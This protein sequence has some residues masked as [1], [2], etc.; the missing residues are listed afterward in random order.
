MVNHYQYLGFLKSQRW[1]TQRYHPCE[2]LL[3]E[4]TFFFVFRMV[5]WNSKYQTST[6]NDRTFWCFIRIASKA[7]LPK[8]AYF[9]EN[10]FQSS[11][12]SFFWVTTWKS[13][14]IGILTNS[15]LLYF[16]TGKYSADIISRWRV[17]WKTSW[18]V[19]KVLIYIYWLIRKWFDVDFIL[20]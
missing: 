10:I 13:D 12:I 19:R 6:K 9:Q 20:L 18:V 14:S 17:R 7:V 8:Q 4:V 3:F 2:C 1:T 11:S 15:W 5:E 16:R